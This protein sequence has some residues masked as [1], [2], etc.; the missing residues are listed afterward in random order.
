MASSRVEAILSAYDY[1][2]VTRGSLSDF[3][4]SQ[5]ELSAIAQMGANAAYGLQNQGG[6]QLQG[7]ADKLNEITTGIAK[8]QLPQMQVQLQSLESL[9]PARPAHP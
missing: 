5:S 8:G 9:L 6:P 2:E 4:I 1:I 7:L 3:R